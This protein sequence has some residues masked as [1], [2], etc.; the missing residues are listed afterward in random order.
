LPAVPRDQDITGSPGLALSP[1]D[2][3][4]ALLVF[5]IAL[6]LYGA[7]ALRLAEGRYYE[8]F[9]L[10]F[11]FDA[12][13]VLSMLTGSPPDGMGFKHPL[14][15]YLRPLGLGAMALDLPPKAAAGMV[16][17]AV[18]AGTVVLVFLFLRCSRIA[19]PEALALSL[20][21]V[22]SGSQVVTAIVT[23]S[24][25]FAAFS[26]ALVWLIARLRMDDP[27][28]LGIARTAAAVFAGGVTTTNALQPF[29]AEFAILWRHGGFRAAVIGIIRFGI[30][31]GL[32]FAAAALLLWART[33]WE[34]LQD[35]VGTAKMIW[36]LQ[37]QGE[38]TG[39]LAV[40]RTYLVLSFVSPDFT[41]LPLP[42]G[43]RML[44][45]REWSFGPAGTL[46]AWGWMAFLAVG[47]AAGL[48]HPG[49]RPIALAILVA[50][51]VNLV[52][53]L[54]FQFRGSLYLYAA[55]LH[56]VTFALAAGLAPWLAGRA[57][58]LR[59]GYV[60]AVLALAVLFGVMNLSMAVDFVGRFDIPDTPC[61]AP[62]T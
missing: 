8:Y 37:T 11:D 62:C 43:T 59:G 2:A 46:A 20:L 13:R 49:Y 27:G 61:P 32:V 50:L 60:A 56:F 19:R 29:I 4:L 51:L 25:G 5:A 3:L 22:V 24:Y 6:A 1:R 33:I 44:D 58:V 48:A 7:L 41:V 9:N 40:L 30:L 52:F 36:W 23:E 28:R 38:K 35:P 16:M 26:L 31:F 12:S 14:M 15:L 34:A 18:G 21:F 47:T 10:A 57:A 39:P 17:A 45:F 54:R 55:H 53:H 42:E